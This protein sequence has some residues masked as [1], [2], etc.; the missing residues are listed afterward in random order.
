MLNALHLYTMLPTVHASVHEALV[1][2]LTLVK[3]LP[4]S[5]KR[6]PKRHQGSQGCS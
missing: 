6:S 5:L 4:E 3:E 2:L 1:N